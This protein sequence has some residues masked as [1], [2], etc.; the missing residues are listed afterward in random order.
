MTILLLKIL[1]QTSLINYINGFDNL[2]STPTFGYLCLR[3]AFN[4]RVGK[5][6][7]VDFCC[8]P[9]QWN[10]DQHTHQADAQGSICLRPFLCKSRQNISWSVYTP[11]QYYYHQHPLLCQTRHQLISTHTRPI[12]LPTASTSLPTQ[13]RHH[14]ISTHTRPILTA[15]YI[16]I[17]FSANPDINQS[18][19]TPSPLHF[20]VNPDKLSTDQY[21]HQ[22][23][24]N[25]GACLCTLLCQPRQ[26]IN[27]S[28]HTPD[29][30]QQLLCMSAS[31][32]LPN[33]TNYQLI[34]THTRP[35]PTAAV[36]VYIHFSAKPD[37]ASTDQYTHQA[38]TITNSC[39]C[40][41]PLFCQ[42]RRDS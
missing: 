36:Y 7:P 9:P 17:H 42:P 1:S 41:H 3:Q 14:L 40:V 32:S 11:G 22:A 28:V 33:Q 38:N 21:T 4:V 5:L 25:S 18:V 20:S 2:C 10:T 12:L 30:Y 8:L 19:R 6:H 31:T 16:C 35:I 23:N 27:Q 34:S 37:K 29:Q 13:T 39:V 15:A 24:A 26:D